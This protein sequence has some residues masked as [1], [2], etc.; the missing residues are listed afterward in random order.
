M[1]MLVYQKEPT[2]IKS[3]LISLDEL[4]Y[5]A[6]RGAVRDR[7]DPGC[8]GVT[9]CPS[10]SGLILLSTGEMSVGLVEDI[11]KIRSFMVYNVTK[12]AV[13]IYI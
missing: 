10:D 4:I 6:L 12:F 3:L 5:S 11:L 9:H 7:T 8:G 13:Y 1:V 2:T